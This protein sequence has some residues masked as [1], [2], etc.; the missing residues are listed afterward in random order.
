MTPVSIASLRCGCSRISLEIESGERRQLSMHTVAIMTAHEF[1][2]LHK[3][4][5]RLPIGMVIY[6]WPFCAIIT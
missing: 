3:T 2:A 1:Q 4:I 5:L 6:R